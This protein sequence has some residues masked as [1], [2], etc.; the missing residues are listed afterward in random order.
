MGF[1]KLTRVFLHHRSLSVRQGSYC[2]TGVF[3]HH[4]ILPASQEYFCITGFFC[5]TCLL[6]LPAILALFAD[7]ATGADIGTCATLGAHIGVNRIL[8]ALGDSSHRTFIDASTASD[9]IVTNNVSHS[10]SCFIVYIF[11]IVTIKMTVQRYSEFLKS[12]RGRTFIFRGQREDWEQ[13]R[14]RV[15]RLQL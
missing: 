15:G 13:V 5:L 7:G 3:L 9:T 6:V 14:R 10:S 12:A 2:L 8:L 11:T 1:R 4:R